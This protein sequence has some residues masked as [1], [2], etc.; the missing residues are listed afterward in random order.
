MLKVYIPSTEE[1]DSETNLFITTKAQEIV[2]E[3]SLVSLSKWESKWK[4]PF[5]IKEPKKYEESIDYIRCMT[6]TQNVDPMVYYAIPES[7]MTR[8]NDYMADKMTATWF[9][10]SNGRNNRIVTAELIYSWMISL[11]IPFECQKWHLERLMTL[12]RVCN[13]ENKPSGGKRRSYDMMSRQYSENARR[14]QNSHTRG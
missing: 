11:N 8:I 6:I 5:L 12:I 14:R 4:K 13:E 2:L 9:G 1:Y 10:S 3:H 7:E